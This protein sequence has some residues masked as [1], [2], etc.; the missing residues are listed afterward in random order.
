M[1]LKEI[2]KQTLGNKISDKF[3]GVVKVKDGKMQ[4]CYPDFA[5]EYLETHGEEEV[6]GYYYAKSKKTLVVALDPKDAYIL[7]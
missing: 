4:K 3:I 2:A 6:Y 5:D 7:S 1:T